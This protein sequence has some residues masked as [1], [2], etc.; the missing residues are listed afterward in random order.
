MFAVDDSAA[1]ISNPLS[2][3]DGIFNA[4]VRATLPFA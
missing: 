4:Q 1:A 2:L 3:I